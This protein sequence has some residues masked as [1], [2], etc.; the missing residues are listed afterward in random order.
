M[1]AGVSTQAAL[2]GLPDDADALLA[3]CARAN[4]YLAN[5]LS[6]EAAE[7]TTIQTGIRTAANADGI[8]QGK[9][10][11]ESNKTDRKRAK[12]RDTRSPTR[13][14][15]AAAA[16]AQP[17]P[18]F[19]LSAL[20]GWVGQARQ[21]ELAAAMQTGV[22]LGLALP[23]PSAAELVQLRALEDAGLDSQMLRELLGERG[24]LTPRD[25]LTYSLADM[26]VLLRDCVVMHLERVHV[27]GLRPLLAMADHSDT[28]GE[29]GAANDAGAGESSGG[30]EDD[31]LPAEAAT[32]QPTSPPQG[33][34]A[35]R[36]PAP[37]RSADPHAQW[38]AE[39]LGFAAD[40]EDLER[41]GT[42]IT[43]TPP[44]CLRA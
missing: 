42:R 38:K 19:S 25:V 16:A 14:T 41:V 20:Q 43:L 29:G 37:A 26:H 40:P 44:H 21:E 36:V 6:E 11:D 2:A 27:E 3:V 17:A 1:Q 10:E 22:E 28:D 39:T 13:K 32:R 23:D 9:T 33:A 34:T 7:Q 31:S 30:D 4:C 5:S 35:A 8:K 24:L 18:A 12:G 15:A